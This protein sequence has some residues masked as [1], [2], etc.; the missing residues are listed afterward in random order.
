MV[1]AL[2]RISLT[3]REEGVVN[4][5]AQGFTNRDISRQLNLSEN[6]DRNYLFRI[7][8]QLGTSNRLE[9]ALYSTNRQ[10]CNRPVAAHRLFN[11]PNDKD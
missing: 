10:D 7:F 2:R 5:V 6:T 11:T 1:P 8:N 9:L 4:L 3:D